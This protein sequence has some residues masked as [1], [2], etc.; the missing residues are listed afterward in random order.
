MIGTALAIGAGVGALGGL[1]GSLGK[2][3]AIQKQLEMLDQKKRDNQNWFDRRYNEDSTQ[4]ADAQ[5]LLKITEDSM[6][7]RTKAAA[8][9]EAVMGGATENT[10]REKE[11][12]NQVMADAV[13]QI[14][15]AGEQRKDQIEAQYRQQKDALEQQEA[16]LKGQEPN[17]FDFANNIIGGAAGGASLA[18]GLFGGKKE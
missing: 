10:M 3:S 12:A 7:K 13:S 11:A 6:R 9:R 1:F 5:R 14:N 2:R 8:G 18:N 4:R 16:A 15:A 17:G